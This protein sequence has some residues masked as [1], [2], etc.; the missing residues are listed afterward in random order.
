MRGPGFAQCGYAIVKRPAQHDKIRPQRQSAQ[1]VEP[2][3]NS[4][5]KDNWE[6][7]GSADFRQYLDTG[8]RAVK[9]PTAVV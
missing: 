7:G 3:F 6:I 8:R 2:A 9:L 4:A 5:V 1:D